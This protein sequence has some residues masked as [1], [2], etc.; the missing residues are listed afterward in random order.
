MRT[1]RKAEVKKLKLAVYLAIEPEGGSV[2]PWPGKNPF[3]DQSL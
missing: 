3:L 2:P 1:T